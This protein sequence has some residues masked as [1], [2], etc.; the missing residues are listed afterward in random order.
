MTVDSDTNKVMERLTYVN[1]DLN[2]ISLDEKS[3]GTKTLLNF[4]MLP[5]LV[6][7]NLKDPDLCCPYEDTVD[8]EQWL[9]Q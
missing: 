8:I 1:L 5:D 6:H 2:E 3:L 4:N 7:K 9:T